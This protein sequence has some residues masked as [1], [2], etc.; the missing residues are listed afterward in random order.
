MTSC[1]HN[2]VPKPEGYNRIV[3]PRP[4]FQALPDSFPFSFEY[5]KYAKIL[6]DTSWIAEK[7]WFDIYYPTMGASIEMSYK[8]VKG[9]KKLLKEYMNTA[10][11]LTAKHEV[12]AYSIEEKILKTN[13]G[14]T[15]V[16]A[17]LMGEVPSQY[18]FY[19][20][21]SINHFVRGAL[22]F[23]TATKNDSLAPVIVYIRNDILHMLNTLTWNNK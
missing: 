16:L 20:T 13:S 10:Y 7:Y 11:R 14:R 19:T 17:E 18:Q 23:N 5:S 6:P 2:Y 9:S 3:L 22:Y 12:K 21:D 4:A 1:E 8:P 15:A